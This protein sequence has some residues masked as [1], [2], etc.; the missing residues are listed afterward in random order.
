MVYSIN[1]FSK[2]CLIVALDQN[3]NGMKVLGFTT[4]TSTQTSLVSLWKQGG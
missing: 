1:S 2:K 3:D 4:K